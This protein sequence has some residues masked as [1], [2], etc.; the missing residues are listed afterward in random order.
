VWGYVGPALML[1]LFVVWTIAVV[2]YVNGDQ[3][4]R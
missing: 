1:A 2:K 3:Q 4:T